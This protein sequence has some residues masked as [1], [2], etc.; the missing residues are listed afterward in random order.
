MPLVRNA[1]FLI[2]KTVVSGK[3]SVMSTNHCTRTY[4]WDFALVHFTFGSCSSPSDTFHFTY[5][6][7]NVPA[8]AQYTMSNAWY[9]TVSRQVHRK[10]LTQINIYVYIY[11]V[12]HLQG[13]WHSYM[14]FGSSVLLPVSS[15]FSS[16]MPPLCPFL[17]ITYSPPV[18]GPPHCPS[19]IVRPSENY[20]P[21]GFGR[22]MSSSGFPTQR[23][24]IKEQSTVKQST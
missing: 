3:N 12:H 15:I 2:V 19:P 5:H 7:F 22:P 18:S 17:C 14:N 23:P 24:I 6:P 11:I 1:S 10:P 13:Q 8:C 9:F 21:S 4:F 16:Y 20:Q